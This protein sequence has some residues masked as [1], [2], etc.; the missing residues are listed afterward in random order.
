MDQRGLGIA[1]MPN[2]D[3]IQLGGAV[4]NASTHGTNFRSLDDVV[5]HNGAADCR[6]P[7]PEGDPSSGKAV[8][9]TLRRDD[10]D[11]KNRAWFEAAICQLCSLRLI[12]LR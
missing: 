1:S 2:V 11:P 9:Q 6:L 12:Y 7:A 3:T 4:S 10:P 5:V 8:L